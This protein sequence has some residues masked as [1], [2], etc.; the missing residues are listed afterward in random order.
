MPL[1]PITDAKGIEK[2]MPKA[3]YR[4]E[5]VA[6]LLDISVH[7]VRRMAKRGE[8]ESAKVC[9]GLRILRASL[10]AYLL[11]TGLDVNFADLSEGAR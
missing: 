2:L 6:R 10:W 3:N 4:P 7:S 11:R 5:A 1:D 8:L 9:G